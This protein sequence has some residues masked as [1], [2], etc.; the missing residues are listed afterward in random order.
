MNKIIEGF[1]NYCVSD[2]GFVTNV[3][4]GKAL[5]SR[6]GTWGYHQLVLYGEKK[7][8]TFLLHRLVAQYFCEGYEKGKVVNHINGDKDD[9]RACNLEWITQSENLKHAFLNGLRKQDT[10][11]K[12]VVAT[13]MVTGKK[14]VYRSIYEAAKKTGFSQGN[15]C[16][17][18]KNQRPYANGFYWQYE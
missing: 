16:L 8:S 18:C 7:K 10:S 12:S 17:C 9:N 11:A 2:E 5:K 14:T 6:Q 4:T 15:I 3:I 13:D 1:E